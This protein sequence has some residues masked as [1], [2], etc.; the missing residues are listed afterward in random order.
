MFKVIVERPRRTS[1][2]GTYARNR[3]ADEDDLPTKISV[4]RHVALARRRNK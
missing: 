2:M 1:G 4:K 3:L